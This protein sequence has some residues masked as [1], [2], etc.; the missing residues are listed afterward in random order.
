MSKVM[1]YSGLN[2]TGGDGF[3]TYLKLTPYSV[4]TGYDIPPL[5]WLLE[6]MIPLST[7]TVLWAPPKSYK[8]MITAHMAMSLAVGRKEWLGLPT[9]GRPVKV[10]WLDN[11]MG[12]DTTAR[13]IT[14]IASGIDREGT[15]PNARDTWI[16]N[17]HLFT[18]QTWKNAGMKVPM[19]NTYWSEEL[20]VLLDYI[21]ANGIELVVF[22]TL[23][24][25]RNSADETNADMQLV[26]QNLKNIRDETKATIIVLH[27]ST[28]TGEKY[29]GASSIQGDLDQEITIEP[30]DDGCFKLVITKEREDGKGS[31]TGKVT[32]EKDYE[33]RSTIF[34]KPATYDD[35][36][37]YAS[38]READV[39]AYI[40][41]NPGCNWS[42]LRRD[43]I[44][45]YSHLKE[46]IDSLLANGIIT[47]E[48][49]AK[50][51]NIY[52]IVE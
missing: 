51:R 12:H 11:D 37:Q 33:G 8:T 31:V 29:R 34:V 23:T 48:K 28:K 32:S 19:L 10:L 18:S 6:S 21:K 41:N 44:S 9:V 20:Q 17:F 38:R 50:N 40:R 27:H 7:I 36:A 39:L 24:A 4:F 35:T 26:F 46:T 5:Q 15:T 42:S 25:F 45:S 14:A 3:P 47:C 22:D 2:E 43:V 1:E 52:R 13:R 30:K 16:K 49:G